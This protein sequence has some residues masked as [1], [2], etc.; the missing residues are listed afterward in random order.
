M[1]RLFI[2]DIYLYIYTYFVTQKSQ[3]HP[4][5]PMANEGWKMFVFKSSSGY[6]ALQGVVSN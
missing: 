1:S 5:V 6:L 3:T 4:A 2:A